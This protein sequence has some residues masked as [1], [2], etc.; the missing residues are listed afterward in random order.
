MNEKGAANEDDVDG[1]NDDKEK[2]SFEVHKW[3]L[4]VYTVLFTL[5]M[6]G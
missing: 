4:N 3:H 1:N 6:N 2:F 5:I